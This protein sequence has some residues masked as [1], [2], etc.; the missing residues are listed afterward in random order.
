MFSTKDR[1]TLRNL[2]Q[3]QLETANS[4]KNKTRVAEW[5]KH[6]ALKGDR[7]MI[8]IET[9]TFAQEVVT[10]RL[11]CEDELARSLEWN[12]IHNTI[13]LREYD[14]DKIV[15]DYFPVGINSHF[16][17]FGHVVTRETATDSAG[18]ESL[19]HQFE[20]WIQDLEDD[21]EKLQDSD[22]GVD[23]KST[24][25]Y[26]TAA[27]EAFGDILPAKLEGG[28]LYAVPTQN[29]VHIM[30][31]ESMFFAMYDYPD[32]F[33]EMMDRMAKDYIAYFKYL[34]KG[35]F[36]LPTTDFQGVGQG[37]WAFTDELK[38]EGPLKTTD[39]WGFMD[40]Q[41]TVGVS[42]EMFA[43]FIF[44]CYKKISQC[45]GLLSYGCCE[46]VD[47]FWDM[48]KTLPNLR[49]V[50]VSPWCNQE[51]MANELRGSKTIFHRKPSP[52]YLGVGANLDE[53]AF[54]AH[55]GETIRIARGC[56]LEITQRDVYTVNHS[57]EK[58]HRY[59][60]IIREEIEKGW[61]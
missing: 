17:P 33:K 1:E 59:V 55:I 57:V 31:M 40:S 32:L 53:E 19:G 22:F 38:K 37:T 46:P 54:R 56:K 36:L 45:F 3:I 41:E 14:D 20:H 2:A 52:N 42:K 51:F 15:T 5:K 34:E 30:S 28:C 23:M 10:P 49:K 29:I 21:W 50:S 58:V 25:A 48:I 61:R 16:N 8:H 35:G 43:E 60:E 12:L 27:Q 18:N 39:L 24:E 26:K 9:G 6:N 13:N 11:R 44:P 47:A 4:E 7:P